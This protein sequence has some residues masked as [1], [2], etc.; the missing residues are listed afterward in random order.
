MAFS[1]AAPRRIMDAAGIRQA[2]RTT[3]D[4]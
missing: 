1:L 2:L 3:D 4:R